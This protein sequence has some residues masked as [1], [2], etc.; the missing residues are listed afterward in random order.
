[1]TK[2]QLAYVKKVLE[3]IKAPDAHIQKAI[4]YVDKDI[5]EYEA[6]KGQLSEQYETDFRW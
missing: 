1:M 4:S 3:R 5:A 6:R 2:E